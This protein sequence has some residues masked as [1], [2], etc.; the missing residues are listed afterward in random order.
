MQFIQQKDTQIRHRK[1]SEIF[2]DRQVMQIMLALRV[3]AETSAAMTIYIQHF[4]LLLLVFMQ[5]QNSFE[6]VRSAKA[7]C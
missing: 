3:S 1:F 4:N 6:N 2:S 5:G 7:R